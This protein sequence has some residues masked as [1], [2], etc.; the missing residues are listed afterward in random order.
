[1]VSRSLISVVCAIKCDEWTNSKPD[2]W[3]IEIFSYPAS[4]FCIK[5]SIRAWG[6]LYHTYKASHR[7][8]SMF[9]TVCAYVCVHELWAQL[10]STDTHVVCFECSLF[11]CVSRSVLTELFR[12]SGPILPCHHKNLS[13]PSSSLSL[14]YWIPLYEPMNGPKV[15]RWLCLLGFSF[16]HREFEGYFICRRRSL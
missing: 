12:T 16:S 3:W 2:T 5:L 9:S 4:T 6:D 13:L 8:K 10:V 15:M 1:M 11:V 7:R 14:C